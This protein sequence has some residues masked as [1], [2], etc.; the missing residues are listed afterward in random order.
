MLNMVQ[1]DKGTLKSVD[2]LDF[3]I[4][5]SKAALVLLIQASIISL[6]MS[7][8][9]C[10]RCLANSGSGHCRSITNIWRASSFQN[11][12]S[13]VAEPLLTDCQVSCS[14]PRWTDWAMEDS[15]KSI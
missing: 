6:A 7:F 10:S 9:L 13:D 15:I 14:K 11:R 1:T 2:L 12:S 3:C 4:L 5:L 8:S